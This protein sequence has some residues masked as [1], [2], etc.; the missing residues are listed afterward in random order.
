MISGALFLGVGCGH[1][2]EVPTPATDETAAGF[3]DPVEEPLEMKLSSDITYQDSVGFDPEFSLLDVYYSNK[4]AANGIVVYVHGGSWRMGSKT[5]YPEIE[6]FA[7]YFVERGYIVASINYR[8]LASDQAP[9]ATYQ[10][11]ASDIA[12]AVS[13]MVMNAQAFG[14]TNTDVI[15]YGHSSG[16]HMSALIGTDRKYLGKYGLSLS[17]IKAVISSDVHNYNVPWAIQRMI[18]TRYEANIPSIKSYF[19]ETAEIQKLA[20]PEYYISKATD[21]PPMLLLSAGYDK[22]QASYG[23]ITDEAQEQF[24]DKLIQAGYMAR[25][26]HFEND[27]HAGMLLGFGED[28]DGQ[29]LA[30]S[31]FLEEL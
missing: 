9:G 15:L 19:G 1:V 18:G 13:Y 2:G 22:P 10:D 6:N 3:D 26:V 7:S 17:D 24:K 8:L 21:I 30:V 14:A 12:S 28:T 16:A 31:Q 25:H 5:S 20:S 29:T 4:E 27:T 23:G 11:Q